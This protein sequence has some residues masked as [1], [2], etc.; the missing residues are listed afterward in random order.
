MDLDAYLHRI[1]CDG[2]RT[3]T[4]ETL[5][6]IQFA[7]STT[8]PFE[9]LNPLLRWPVR[10]DM[11]SLEAK[12]VHGGRGGWCFEHNLLLMEALK[13][14]GF[15]VTGLAARVLWNVPEGV[16]TSR[17][18]M[19]LRIGLGGRD[20]IADVGFGGLTLTGPLLLEADIEQQTPHEPFRL[21]RFG[22]DFT[23]EAKVVGNWKALYRFDLQEQFPQDYEIANHFLATH[24][25]S[26]FLARLFVARP[27][28]QARYGLLDNQLT[29]HPLN[30]PSGHFT[31]ESV[32]ELRRT[33]AETF[34]LSLPATPEVEAMLS[35]TVAN[36]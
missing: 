11:P 19:L 10:L 25:S 21:R 7:H 17:G 8:I 31:L 6:A 34:G 33:L 30:G 4:L 13:T 12:L 26:H 15:R 32:A 16:V 35:R 1:A 14:L 24:P 18:H 9:N 36:T 27:T 5:R 2:A 23:L 29:T 20:Y 28:S 3:P 22:N